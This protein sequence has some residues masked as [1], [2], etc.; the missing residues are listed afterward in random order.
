M[1]AFTRVLEWDAADPRSPRIQ[2]AIQI[3]ETVWLH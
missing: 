3:Y 1:T 2:T